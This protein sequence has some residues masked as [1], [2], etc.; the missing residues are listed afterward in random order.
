MK[1]I[2][3]TNEFPFGV[4]PK[5][6]HELNSEDINETEC[7]SHCKKKL[8]RYIFMNE[9]DARDLLK[10]DLKLKIVKFVD[11]QRDY[12]V[13]EDNSDKKERLLMKSLKLKKD[14]FSAIDNL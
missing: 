8:K 6:G 14:I 3:L 12:D 10:N 9:D 1:I 5:C 2:T 13:A 7:C 11:L 4:C